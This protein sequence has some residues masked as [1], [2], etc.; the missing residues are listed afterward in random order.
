MLTGNFFCVK[1]RLNF[2]GKP[3]ITLCHNDWARSLVKF[4]PKS[5][6]I[7]VWSFRVIFGLWFYALVILKYCNFG[8][9]ELFIV[10]KSIFT[11]DFSC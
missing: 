10:T 8:I 5:W 9:L 1:R 7:W 6:A 2:F 4:F 11:L 3:P